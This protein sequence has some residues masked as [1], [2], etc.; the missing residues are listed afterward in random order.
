[1]ITTVARAVVAREWTGFV[2]ALR[3]AGP[4]APDRSTRC[5]GW[6]VAD[7]A[8][9]VHWGMTLETDGLRR[10]RTGT[11]GPAEGVTPATDTPWPAVVDA[12]ARARDALLDELDRLAADEH[13]RPLPM[14]YGDLPVA[15]A[16]PVFAMEA[17][18]HGSDLAHALGGDDTLAPDVCAA[19]VAFLRVYAPLLA[20]AAGTTAAAGTVIVL[21]GEAGELRLGTDA[22]GRWRADPPGDAT[23][24]ITGP[25]SPL[26][27]FALGRRPLD[28]L[29]VGGDADLAAAFPRLIPGP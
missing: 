4:D 8:N 25:D 10:A 2:E 26:W 13:D 15:L 17:G 5:A 9:H 7:L 6:Q 18:V 23:V 29:T 28:G 24:A 20:N 12:L 14:P 21:R 3:R 27:L 22:D 16:R 1:M 19:T 11:A